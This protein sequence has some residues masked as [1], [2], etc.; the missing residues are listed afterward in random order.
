MPTRTAPQPRTIRDAYDAM[1]RWYDRLAGWGEAAIERQALLM[2]AAREGED[3]LELGPGTGRALLAL[4][5]VVGAS[6]R[7]YGVDLSIGML[8]RARERLTRAGQGWRAALLCGDI[9]HLPLRASSADAALSI[10]TLE[11]LDRDGSVRA[12][13][14]CRRV[15]RPGGRLVVAAMAEGRRRQPMVRLYRWAR[16][17]Y[18]LWVNCRPIR[19]RALLVAA[20]FSIVDAAS[21]S[22]WGLPVEIVLATNPTPR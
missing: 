15:L 5:G 21:T 2:L 16:E 13:A 4:A 6:G 8:R 19:P 20:G 1:S 3:I 17:R 10:L 12:L 18:P 7:L 14:E 9:A 11:V 22:A